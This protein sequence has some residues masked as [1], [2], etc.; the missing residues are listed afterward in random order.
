M[1]RPFFKKIFGFRVR[2]TVWIFPIFY[3]TLPIGQH[4]I[5]YNEE[6]L[7]MEPSM[8]PMDKIV[9]IYNKHLKNAKPSFT[10]FC[11]SLGSFRITKKQIRGESRQISYLK[12][13]LMIKKVQRS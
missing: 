11:P 5:S 10:L 6:C 13:N 9:I 4:I 1:Y 7:N 12:K 8:K 3:F 2:S